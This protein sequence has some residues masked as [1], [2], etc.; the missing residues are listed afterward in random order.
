MK[1]KTYELREQKNAIPSGKRRKK[2][3]YFL[4]TL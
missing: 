2:D 1:I 3:K 4:T